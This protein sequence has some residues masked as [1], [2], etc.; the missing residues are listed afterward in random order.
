MY[1]FKLPDIGEGISEAQLIEW[2]VAVGDRVAEGDPIASVSTDKVDVE[3]PAP[4]DGTITELCWEPGDTIKVGQTLVRIDGGAAEEKDAAPPVAAGPQ[5]APVFRAPPRPVRSELR[6]V[7]A[8]SVRRYAAE[9]RIELSAII[10]TGPEGRILQRDVEVALAPV[11]E[12][13][14]EGIR[15]EALTPAR[16]VQAKNL[17]QAVHTLALSTINFE[18]PADDLAAL[19]NKVRP[20]AERRHIKLTPLAL[21][22]KCVAHALNDHPRLNATVDED[23]M[24]L[25]MYDKVDLGIAVAVPGR[26]VV[27]IVR[28]ADRLTLLD[29][30]AEIEITSRQ[31]HANEIDVATLHGGTF[32]LSSTGG[33][34]TATVVSTRPI[35]N[36]PQVAILWVSRIRDRPRA[37]DGTF[38]VGPTINASL[39]F[40]HR[41]IDGAEA[42]AF[43]ND[44][45]ACF[46][47]PESAL[48]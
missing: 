3:L 39:S 11:P 18:T 4:C 44:V 7:A 8:P 40:D 15:R 31:A 30:A 26:L 47:C 33:L 22:A 5:A 1:D 17:A 16:A 24:E 45:A 37:I 41:F 29:L 12:A 9:H 19:L 43:V 25:I 6:V 36:P 38:G 10:G 21:I 42:M 23:R 48:A 20:T 35:V 14:A 13:I 2:T 28:G 32:T 34:E 46:G 27:P